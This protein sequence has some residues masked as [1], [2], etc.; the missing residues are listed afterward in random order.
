V[1][2]WPY[3]LLLSTVH[4]TI[5]WSKNRLS[6]LRPKWVILPYIIDQIL[7]YTSIAL[8]ALWIERLRGQ[9]DLPFPMSWM[10]YAIVYLLV[11]YVWFISER[12]LVYSNE[13][14]RKEL[15]EQFWSRMF[16]RALFMSG[17]LFFWKWFSGIALLST[18]VFP[19]PYMNGKNGLRALMTDV[20]VAL[21]GMLFLLWVGA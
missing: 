5:D 8:V 15:A 11:T 12:I 3:L 10:K 6:E 9:V 4:L 2:I 13:D 19:L 16:A 18:L 17:F 14:Y 1:S 7:H 20:S 21:A